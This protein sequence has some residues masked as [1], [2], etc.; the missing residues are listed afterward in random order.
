MGEQRLRVLR[1]YHAGRDRS[2]RA[3][4]RAL[5]AAGVDV[6]L[7]VPSQWPES[8]A[9]PTLSSEPFEVVPLPVSRAG[10]VNRHRYADPA[11]LAAVIRR[12][13]PDLVD[14][15]E[16]PFSAVTHQI[17]AALP[18]GTPVVGYTAQNLDKR[19]PPP[20]TGW[21]RQAFG[22]LSA[23]APCSRQA[24]SVI[25][26]R[27]YAGLVEV[28]PL[29]H[30]PAVFSP[31]DQKHTDEVFQLALAGRLVPE[32]GVADAVE[33][34]AEVRRNRE[35][36]LVV[37]GSGPEAA[38]LPELA[39]QWGVAG[40]VDLLPWAEESALAGI[41]R[42]SHVVVVPSQATSRWVEQ[43]GRG[44][45]EAQASG[46]RRR[47]VCQR[48][49]P[50]GGGRRCLAVGGGRPGRPGPRRRAA[51]PGP[52]RVG[53]VAAAR[54]RRR[55]GQAVG[56]RRGP[57]GR[58]LRPCR[59]G[60]SGAARLGPAR[61]PGRRLAPS[62]ARRRRRATASSGRSPYRC[63]V[64]SRGSAGRSARSPTSPAADPPRVAHWWGYST[65][66][67]PLVGL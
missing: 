13:D 18:A 54:D 63:C 6:V 43:F 37:V 19:Y 46:A 5:A 59:R 67:G 12:V 10:D 24:A 58:S 45:V 60:L 11:A 41:Y 36:R 34:L 9:E 61:R 49:H 33:V 21:E 28:L 22:R 51:R 40:H 14:L 3:R 47:R 20:F 23:I 31:G 29:G 52:G 7:V 42:D 4:E 15:H 27:G 38:R 30:D 64:T 44:V 66:H 17:L 35:A 8:G 1:V 39:T 32:K 55:S 57:A 56:C 25:R 16:E 62:S 65:T 26:G 53:G 50:R 48:D 2:H